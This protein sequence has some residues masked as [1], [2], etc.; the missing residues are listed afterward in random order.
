MELH[1]LFRNQHR[2]PYAFLSRTMAISTPDMLLCKNRFL[3]AATRFTSRLINRAPSNQ[4]VIRAVPA[5]LALKT[6][7][8]RVACAHRVPFGGKFLKLSRRNIS[9]ITYCLVE[10]SMPSLKKKNIQ[11]KKKHSDKIGK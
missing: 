9:D 2:L 1:S 3:H 11:K 8:K 5:N 4:E 10:I 7:S 6:N